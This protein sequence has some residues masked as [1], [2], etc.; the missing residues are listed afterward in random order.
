M[1]TKLN[2]RKSTMLLF[3][4]EESFGSF[5]R[6]NISDIEFVPEGLLE[7]VSARTVEVK[8]NKPNEIEA[9]LEATYLDEVFQLAQAA[10]KDTSYEKIVLEVKK[11]AQL[12]NIYEIRNAVSHPNRPF[13]DCY[14]YKLAALLVSQSSK[15]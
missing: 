15:S 8:S 3:T 1:D 14:W 4:I 13:V 9:V 2:K 12:Y 11:L 7:S 10:T 6:G 5:V